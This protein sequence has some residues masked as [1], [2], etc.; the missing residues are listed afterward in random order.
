MKILWLKNELL[1]PV[2]K[3]GKIRT[4]NMLKRLRREHHITYLALAPRNLDP[5]CAVSAQEYCDQLVTVEWNTTARGGPGFYFDLARNLGSA[6]PYAIHKYRTDRMRRAIRSELAR[7]RYDL[8]V[9]DFLTPSINVPRPL[10]VPSLLF[11]H[12]VESSIWRRHYESETN[13][14]KK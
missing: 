4:Y 7:S 8:L 1:H 3:G 6:I 9:C 10:P 2:D 14:V 5:I 11:Q 12:N 13:K